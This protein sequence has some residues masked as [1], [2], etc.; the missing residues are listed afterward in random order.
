MD[1]DSWTNARQRL[2]AILGSS[3]PLGIWGYALL[4][5]LELPKDAD[6]EEAAQVFL[7]FARRLHAEEGHHT[8]STLVLAKAN[9]PDGQ[10]WLLDS[11][12][13][14][15]ESAVATVY[16]AIE[17]HDGW[18]SIVRGQLSGPGRK[19]LGRDYLIHKGYGRMRVHYKQSEGDLKVDLYNLRTTT[20]VLLGQMQQEG[21]KADELDKLAR[22][23]AEVTRQIP[24][25]SQLRN[26]LLDELRI[27]DR[28]RARDGDNEILTTLRDDLETL[29]EESQLM[30][31]QVRDTLE[32][33]STT[34]AMARIQV[35]KE[36]ELRQ[37]E[38]RNAQEKAEKAAQ[39][40]QQS[41]Q[42]WLALLA[43]VL[44]VP[45]LID[46]DTVNEVLHLAGR[47]A[48]PASYNASILLAVRAG[49]IALI[50]VL[51][52]LSWLIVAKVVAWRRK[53]LVARS[54]SSVRDGL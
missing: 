38:R 18:G 36:Q 33:A 35:D 11:P 9:L 34:V 43:V 51:G 26:V 44:A 10:V 22:N 13:T 21:V 25:L 46:G 8:E 6:L 49:I 15:S 31:I 28:W 45:Q 40:R 54:N 52:L 17:R 7:P 39:R 27:Y 5:Q 3:C 29:A 19:L 14:G 37:Q 47:S 30:I 1:V 53:R 24:K 16:A 48:L 50:L 32:V 42:V 12:R 2:E 4:Y 23:F 20:N 41:L